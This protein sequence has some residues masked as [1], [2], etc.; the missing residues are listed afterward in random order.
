MSIRVLGDLP[1]DLSVRVGHCDLLLN[2]L[3]WEITLIFDL[4]VC[5]F[6]RLSLSIS[7]T[8]SPSFRKAP[9]MRT[10]ELILY[11]S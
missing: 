10:S 7:P 6:T 4:I 9:F 11:G 8:F 3:R 5:L 1:D 2:F